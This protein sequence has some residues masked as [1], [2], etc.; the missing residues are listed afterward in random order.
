MA[1][2]SPTESGECFS[3]AI[4]SDGSYDVPE[5]LICGYPLI[6]QKDGSV[7]IK[8]DIVLSDFAKSKFKISI[9]EL[10]AEKE[11]IKHLMK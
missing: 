10:L 1:C 5:G 7:D 3:A 4:A 9:D 2:E 11:A 6:T 8:R